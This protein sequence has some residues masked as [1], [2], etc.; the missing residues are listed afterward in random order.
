[1]LPKGKRLNTAL[2][3]KVIE[4]GKIF[5]S[6]AFTIRSIKDKGPLRISVSVPKKIAKTAVMRNKIRRRVYS[7]I[8]YFN[9]LSYEDMKIILI[10]KSS[11]LKMNT[12]EMKPYIKEI[13]VNFG[14][15]K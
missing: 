1:M 10:A 13:F 12:N 7:A 4:T 11:I 14:F 2:F 8:S 9:Y 6:E 15:L 5:H 3:K